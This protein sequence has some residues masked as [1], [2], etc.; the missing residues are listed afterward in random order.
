MV[1]GVGMILVV[2]FVVG[3]ASGS[4]AW[5]LSCEG[6]FG[7]PITRD[8][9]VRRFGHAHVADEPL[10]LGEGFWERGTVVFP[11]SSKLRV[12]ILWADTL[13][14]RA[15]RIVRV[16]GGESRWPGPL[17]VTLGMDLR[18]VERAYR[19][20]LRLTGFGWDGEGTVVSWEG[21]ALQ[22]PDSSS[23]RFRLRF[24]LERAEGAATARLV[25]EVEG[26]RV[27]SSAHP[28]MRALN[29][30]VVAMWLE[31]PDPIAP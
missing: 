9:L 31:Y 2:L 24:G 27:Y 25:R 6:P 19:R 28:A 23:C 22:A 16:R 15:P 5:V 10:W 26:D 14:E 11:D 12:E 3:A 4:E 21:G 30:R 8:E 1:V 18:A 29:P 13:A 20:P 7:Q 17:G